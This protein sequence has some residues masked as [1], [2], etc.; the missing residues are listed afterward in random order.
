MPTSASNTL[1]ALPAALS[2]PNQRRLF[3]H[4]PTVMK[5]PGFGGMCLPAQHSLPERALWLSDPDDLVLLSQPLESAYLDYLRRL[6]AGPGRV[7]SVPRQECSAGLIETLLA[8]PDMS[9]ELA[10][11]VYGA[12]TPIRVD[13]FCVTEDTER[14]TDIL[15]RNFTQVLPSTANPAATFMANHKSCVYAVLDT[16]GI[17]KIPGCIVTTAGQHLRD[18]AKQLQQVI[19]AVGQT[20]RQVV[21]RADYSSGGSGTLLIDSRNPA[22]LHPW[23]AGQRGVQNLLVEAYLPWRSSPNAQF[24]LSPEGDVELFA[25]TDQ[26]NTGATTHDGNIFPARS[27][28]D[29]ALL[30]QSTT[31]A[32]W[33]ASIGVRGFIGIDFIDTVTEGIRFVEVNAR[34][35]GSTYATAIAVRMNH[36]RRAA[37]FPPL[38]AWRMKKQVPSRHANFAEM[39]ESAADL[40]YDHHKRAGVIPYWTGSLSH[41]GCHCVTLAEDPNQLAALE[42]AFLD[43]V[44]AS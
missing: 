24:W 4:D 31:I 20:H 28:A 27:H 26:R 38:R 36:L 30:E 1:G 19:E 11:W 13:L 40:L 44:S 21:V 41:A 8:M 37:G 16:L 9:A 5:D 6:G 25:I 17:P 34:V 18:A 22:D 7:L 3:I 29:L 35:N 39:M 12:S 10:D 2:P 14:V 43:R 33:L 42:S 32:S 15:C 23:L